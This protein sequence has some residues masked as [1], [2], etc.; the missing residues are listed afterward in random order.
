MKS[1]PTQVLEAMQRAI[2]AQNGELEAAY[3]EL[4]SGRGRRPIAIPAGSLERLAAICA[5]RPN[6][7]GASKPVSGI[8]C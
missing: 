8:R 6:P 5:D 1:D 7:V 4:A 2:E 3:A